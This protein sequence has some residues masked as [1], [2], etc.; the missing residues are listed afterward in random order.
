M[1]RGGALRGRTARRSASVET[2][3]DDLELDLWIQR[4]ATDLAW[5]EVQNACDG[6]ASALALLREGCDRLGKFDAAPQYVR[7]LRR[8]LEH[9]SATIE[10][11]RERSDLARAG[12]IDRPG[13]GTYRSAAGKGGMMAG[14]LKKTPST[15]STSAEMARITR[16]L[17][18]TADS[19]SKAKASSAKQR[20]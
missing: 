6:V 20:E 2:E 7:R 4:E 1:G 9:F 15:N 18:K 13:A 17:G 12:A 8:E 3:L 14:H 10:E 16:A 5:R 19:Y 11:L